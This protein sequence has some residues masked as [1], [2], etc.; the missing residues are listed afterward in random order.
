MSK[1]NKPNPPQIATPAALIRLDVG[2]GPNKKGPEWLGI[3]AIKFPGVDVVQDLRKPWPFKDGSVEEI[4]CSHCIEHFTAPERCH[5]YNEMWRVL[6]VGGKSLCITPAWSSGRAY[7]D[8]THQWPPVSSF[9]Y[10]YLLRSWR[11]ANAPHSDAKHWP[12]GYKC[13]FDV[14]W[15]FSL[16]PQIAPRNQEYQQFALNFYTEAAQ[17]LIATFVKR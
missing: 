2:C 9:S 6:R 16:H 1:K 10:Y 4:H 13:D 14:T 12:P 8:P 7:G 17:D 15:G 5:V 11:E 3:D